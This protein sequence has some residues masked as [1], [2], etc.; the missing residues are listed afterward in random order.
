[1]EK[2]YRMFARKL[3]QL[4]FIFNTPAVAELSDKVEY[5]RRCIEREN[6]DA[7]Q[8]VEMSKHRGKKVC[9]LALLLLPSKS[10]DHIIN[11][12]PYKF[13][14]RREAVRLHFGIEIQGCF[15]KMMCSVRQ[16]K[17]NG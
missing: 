12:I 10:R 17:M 11:I 4:I 2:Q 13:H 9:F 16:E 14:N 15:K 7:S 1:M 3:I 6:E 8:V 5:S